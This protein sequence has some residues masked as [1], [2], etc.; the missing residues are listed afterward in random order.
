MAGASGISEQGLQQ[1]WLEFEKII[2]GR[3]IDF[4]LGYE[5]FKFM[6]KII[7]C[8]LKTNFYKPEKRSFAFRL[9]NSILDPLV[10]N[11]F[12][13]GVFFVNGHYSCGTHLRAADIARGGLR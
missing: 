3:F 6:F 4:S 2:A 13:F 10:F 11:S 5:I 9:D 12:V 1:K 7:T 8:T